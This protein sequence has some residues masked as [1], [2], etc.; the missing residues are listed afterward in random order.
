MLTGPSL[1]GAG[2]RS[3]FQG[4]P[5]S[6]LRSPTHPTE[7]DNSFASATHPTLSAHRLGSALRKRKR[8]ASDI[9]L[10][11]WHIPELGVSIRHHSDGSE[12]IKGRGCCG[13][14]LKGHSPHLGYVAVKVVAMPDFEVSQW[15]TPCLLK[16][17]IGLGL[18]QSEDAVLNG[19]PPFRLSCALHLRRMRLCPHWPAD[20]VHAAVHSNFHLVAAPPPAQAWLCTCCNAARGSNLGTR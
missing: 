8:Q 4:K 11:S 9:A 19:K 14:V 12:A 1:G 17:S 16:Y 20:R 15:V 10:T 3:A 2:S 7:P 18:R 5:D 13:R 6:P